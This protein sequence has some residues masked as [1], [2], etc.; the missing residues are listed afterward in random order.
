MNNATAKAS[1]LFFLL[2]FTLILASVFINK[3]FGFKPVVGLNVA[4]LVIATLIMARSRYVKALGVC[5]PLFF[6][7]LGGIYAV[8]ITYFLV[9]LFEGF[10]S[11]SLFESIVSFLFN[12]VVVYVTIFLSTQKT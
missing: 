2:Y 12:S 11:P 9:I 6:A 10:I 7:V 1:G 3:I 8:I 5:N 4:A